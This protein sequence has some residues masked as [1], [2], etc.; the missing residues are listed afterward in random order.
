M[1]NLE[2]PTG[3]RMAPSGE[4][5]AL[6]IARGDNAYIGYLARAA[7]QTIGFHRDPDEEYLI[8]FEGGGTLEALFTDNHGYLSYATEP[9]YGDTESLSGDTVEWEVVQD[10]DTADTVVQFALFGELVYG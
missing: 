6:E 8:I 2:N 7:G 3:A 4:A 9:L 10:A 5:F 1:Q